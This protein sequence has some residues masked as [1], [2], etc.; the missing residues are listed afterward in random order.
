MK[1]RIV[2]YP[3]PAL[4]C[5]ARPVDRVSAN[6]LG[7][8][9]AMFQLMYEGKGVGLA[10]PQVGLPFQLLVLNF[11][12]DRKNRAGEKV[13]LNPTIVRRRGIQEDE[14]GCL[15]LPGLFG[16]VRRARS[17]V[18][19]ARELS[20]RE[21]EIH[22]RRLAARVWQHEI[23]HL[24]GILFIDRLSAAAT[25]ACAGTLTEWERTFRQQQ[26]QKRLPSDEAIARE[27]TAHLEG[28][29]ILGGPDEANRSG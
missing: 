7:V 5:R 11:S 1:L 17:V 16:L 9:D 13:Y 23:D 2:T 29:G 25:V 20:G 12:G 10:A 22:S 26:A 15:S 6:T 14:E 28:P 24:S 4:R 18:V 21:V 19:R 3:H 27:L 8:A